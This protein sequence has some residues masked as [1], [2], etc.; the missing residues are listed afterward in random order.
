MD[1]D[2]QLPPLP[3]KPPVT[4]PDAAM[5][6]Y[7]R[8][9]YKAG[10]VIGERRAKVDAKPVVHQARLGL[11]RDG[12]AWTDATL[13]D[14]GWVVATVTLRWTDDGRVWI[15]SEQNRELAK[16]L[17]NRHVHARLDAADALDGGER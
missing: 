15:D 1:D 14:T 11:S 2:I 16:R 6:A 12:F 8:A 17:R 13:L 7:G 3:P 4:D 10:V 9:C 5:L